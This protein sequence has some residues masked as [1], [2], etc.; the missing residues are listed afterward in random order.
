MKERLQKLRTFLFARH[1]VPFFADFADYLRVLPPSD[2]FIFG[3]LGVLIAGLS[4]ISV[5]A[6]EKKILITEP[7]YGGGLTEGVV[8]SPRFINPLLALSDADRDISALTYAG[9]MGEGPDGALIPVLAESYIVSPDGKTYQFTLRNNAKF[10]DGS[11]VTA[12]DVVFTIQKAQD[13]ALKS[14]EYANWSNVAVT[15]IDSRTVQF[16]LSAPYAPFLE[17]TTLGILPAHLWRTVTNDEFPFSDLEVRPVGAGPFIPREIVRNKNNSITSYTVTSNPN[18]PLGRPYLDSLHFV[19]FGDQSSLQNAV[20]SH[21]VE[22]AS[23]VTAK[24]VVTAP[25]ARVFAVFFN[26]K[27]G[28]LFAK[29]PAREALSVAVDRQVIVKNLLGG[30]AT[31][32]AGPVPPGQGV[33]S[34][35]V[36]SSENRIASSTAILEKGGWK[37]DAGTHEWK[38]ASG[39]TL[40]VTLKTANVPELKRIAEAVQTDWKELGIPTSLQLYESG[41]LNQSVI[42]PRAYQALLFGMVVG[43]SDD[44]YDFWDSKE[45]ASPGLNLTA[46]NNP[47]VDTLLTKIRAE[48]DPATRVKDLSEVNALIAADYPAAFIESPDFVYAVPNDLKGVILPQ[49]TSPADRFANVENWYRRTESVWPFLARSSR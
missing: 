33:V 44:L 27:S 43:K 48:T 15:A 25:Y 21:A 4:L 38:N 32:I 3:I 40:S 19:F 20:T 1:S 2:R 23:G 26:P 10:S 28:D 12:N 14:P 29:Q 41:D 37:L 34:L 45:Q 47:A 39:E 5:Y 31:A 16:T 24:R 49:I 42:Q 36:P 6:L 35:P 13:P 9:L 11:P 8:G 22:S 18:Y 30:Y 7:V 17:D 46:Y